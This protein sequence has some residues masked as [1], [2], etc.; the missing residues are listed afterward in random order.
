MVGRGTAFWGVFLEA[1][2]F[3]KGGGEGVG[4]TGAAKGMV[5]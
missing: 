3:L 1:G 5:A 4:T 2:D